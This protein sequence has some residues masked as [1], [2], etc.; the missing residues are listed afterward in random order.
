[1]SRALMSTPG[2][3]FGLGARGGF[4]E[5]IVAARVV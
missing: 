2:R 3:V 5:N 1:M 4:S